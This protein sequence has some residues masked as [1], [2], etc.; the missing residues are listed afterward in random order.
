MGKRYLLDVQ[1]GSLCSQAAPAAR[2]WP[3]PTPQ[4]CSFKKLT[5]PAFRRK[6][7]RIADRLG[8]DPSA[9]AAVMMFESAGTMRADIQNAIK[10]T[11]LIQFI[12]STARLYGTTVDALKAMTPLEQLDYVEQHFRAQAKRIRSVGDHYLAVFMPALIGL[13]PSY[14]AAAEGSTERVVSGSTLTKGAVYAQNPFSRRGS[15]T[16]GDIT[17][18]VVGIY[19]A[20][21]NRTPIAV[22]M[23]DWSLLGWTVPV[24]LGAGV[25]VG[26]AWA[27]AEL[28]G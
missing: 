27:I 9:I 14:V 4:P 16:V 18:P 6:L 10:A 26:L 15:Y 13:D 28:E 22:D 21:K 1:A 24:A 8:L 3:G 2:G 17:A 7:I 12:P 20:A 25:G 19:N 11:G 5:T 23:T